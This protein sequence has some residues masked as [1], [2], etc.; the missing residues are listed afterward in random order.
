MC[1]AIPREKDTLNN[2][3]V[4]HENISVWFGGHVADWVADAELDGSSQGF[5]CGLEKHT[6]KMNVEQASDHEQILTRTRN[7]SSLCRDNVIFIKTKSTHMGGSWRQGSR[8]IKSFTARVS[9]CEQ[10]NRNYLATP[11]QPPTTSCDACC[12]ECKIVCYQTCTVLQYIYPTKL[13]LSQSQSF[14][15][16]L[17]KMNPGLITLLH[18][19]LQ[20][21]NNAQNICPGH[22]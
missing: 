12:R 5:S 6:Q 4:L 11:W 19:G 1:V 2:V 14:F 9:Q 16:I 21:S 22:I 18:E 13:T 15:I 17:L 20:Y 8:G 10:I 7:H 3:E